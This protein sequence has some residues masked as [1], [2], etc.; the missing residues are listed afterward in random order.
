MVFWGVVWFHV[1]ILLCESC[2]PLVRRL[3]GLEE[4]VLEL[5]QLRHVRLHE[6]PTLVHRPPRLQPPQFQSKSSD[7]PSWFSGKSGVLEV[8]SN[9]DHIGSIENHC[10]HRTSLAQGAEKSFNC[11]P[12]IHLNYK[13]L[14]S[15]PKWST[16]QKCMLPY[17]MK[18]T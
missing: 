17:S 18:P 14:K 8:F 9:G 3:E 2:K 16:Q 13:S 10:D 11:R 15:V 5:P 1:G 12:N 6:G 4:E 7:Q